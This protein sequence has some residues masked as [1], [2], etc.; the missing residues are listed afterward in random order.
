MPV[1]RTRGSTMAPPTGPATTGGPAPKPPDPN[2]ES[3]ANFY[4]SVDSPFNGGPVASNGYNDRTH[5]F[6]A[7]YIN[8]RSYTLGFSARLGLSINRPRSVAALNLDSLGGGRQARNIDDFLDAID[9]PPVVIGGGSSGPPLIPDSLNAFT[10]ILRQVGGGF[11]STQIVQRPVKP[12]EIARFQVPSLGT[13]NVTLRVTFNDGSN[14]ERTVPVTLREWFLASIGDS[15]ASGQ[16]NPDGVASLGFGGGTVCRATTLAALFGLTPNLSTDPDW[17]E[18]KAYRSLRSGPALAALAAQNTGGASADGTGV[19][20]RSI[21]LDKVVFASF[22]R[23]GAEVFDGL[24]RSQGGGGDFVGAGQIEELKRAAAG[25]R[26]DALMLDI[27]GNDAGFSGVLT[28]LVTKD[29]IFK[30]QLPFLGTGDDAKERERINDKLN[31]ILGVGLAVGQKG[32]LENAF[33]A[34]KAAI[35]A[36]DK[37]IGIGGVYWTGYPTGLFEI[38]NDNGDLEFKSCGVFSGPDLDIDAADGRVI[39]KHGQVLN[40]LIKRKAAEFGWRFIDMEPDFR[41]HGYCESADETYWV[42]MEQSC[43]TQGDFQGTMHPNW[44]G[45]AAYGRR[46]ANAIWLRTIRPFRPPAQLPQSPTVNR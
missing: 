25:R 7:S 32:D 4:V 21:T 24:I 16:G 23:S 19:P 33:D 30:K 29:S 34:L 17:L 27:G 38:R 37:Q 40:A 2:L 1:I 11:A 35:D 46:L 14:G 26:V 9:D 18:R 45:Q 43:R 31:Q 20:R 44:R 6:E 39:K 5:R 3:W 41:G 12:M 42:G 36:L 13:Y 10:W 22:A 8:P 15:A 28:D